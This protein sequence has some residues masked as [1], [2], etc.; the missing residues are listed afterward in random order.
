MVTLMKAVGGKKVRRC[1]GRCHDA[2][3]DKC[4]CI[5]GGKNHGA[6]RVQAEQN[7]RE[8]PKSFTDTAHE[9]APDASAIVLFPNK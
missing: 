7:V 2:K 1:N 5:C 9:L 4:T 6:G 3:H 8:D